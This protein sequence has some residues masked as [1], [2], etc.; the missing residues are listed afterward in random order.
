[1]NAHVVYLINDIWPTSKDT[2]IS[3]MQHTHAHWQTELSKIKLKQY[4]IQFNFA[5]ISK[6]IVFNIDSFAFYYI[7]IYIG[8]P[9]YLHIITLHR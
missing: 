5:G 2:P 8:R 6:R 4:K 7:Y 1:M 3:E 9:F